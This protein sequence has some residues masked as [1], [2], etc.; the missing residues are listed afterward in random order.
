MRTHFVA[1][2]P[3]HENH[4]ACPEP[5]A[6]L[7]LPLSLYSPTPHPPSLSFPLSFSVKCCLRR[8]VS[9]SVSVSVPVSPSRSLSHSPSD[10]L[11][12]ARAK[13]LI[14]LSLTA[15]KLSNFPPLDALDRHILGR[16][17]SILPLRC[18]WG[19]WGRVRGAGV[20]PYGFVRERAMIEVR[21]RS[22]KRC[23]CA[24]VCRGVRVCRCVLDYGNAAPRLACCLRDAGSEYRV[25][26]LGF[27]V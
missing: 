8:S 10:I 26:G 17:P 6:S 7:C 19:S 12:P 2:D 23:V 22:W 9:V 27:R 1:G 21:E 14:S 13:A 24:Y 3:V 16:Q 15:I 11:S 4:L 5:P 18:D 25:S 20:C